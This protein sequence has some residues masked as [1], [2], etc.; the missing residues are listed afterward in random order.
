MGCVD[1]TS[2]ARCDGSKKIIA[3]TVQAPDKN[4][5]V[6]NAQLLRELTHVYATTARIRPAMSAQHASSSLLPLPPTLAGKLHT[7]I[8][9][10]CVGAVFGLE[11]ADLAQNS[12]NT[13]AIPSVATSHG[14]N[15]DSMRASSTL[16]LL[17]LLTEDGLEALHREHRRC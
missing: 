2:H 12:A 11:V 4:R 10:A 5:R 17:E 9:L 13:G 6:C 7:T 3:N 16:A 1:C 14:L 8:E 15:G